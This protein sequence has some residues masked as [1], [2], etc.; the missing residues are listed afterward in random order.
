MKNKMKKIFSISVVAIL[1]AATFMSCKD[2]NRV[3]LVSYNVGVFS[4]WDLSSEA[5]SA[6]LMKELNPDVIVLQELDSCT[7]R[8]GVERFQAKTFAEAMGPEWED[9][10]AAALKTYKKGSYGIVE[11][12]NKEKMK[13]VRTFH[14]M[15]PKGMA[16]EERAVIV[17]EYE[18]MV[19]AG[20][21]LNG[22]ASSL[23]PSV[24]I[25]T[26]TLKALYGNSSKPVFL[27]GDFNARPDNPSIDYLRKHW[28]ILTPEGATGI[29]GKNR[30]LPQEPQT[31]EEV[32]GNCIDYIMVLK[33]KAEVKLL[34]S[35]ICF[36]FSNGSAFESSDHLPIYV[37]VSF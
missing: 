28:T 33:N 36:K 2:S 24:E 8:C 34:D 20:T 7:T 37:D 19:F 31:I 1:L 10:Y 22:H 17:V 4:K 29:G 21:H 12:W 32:K 25:I 30:G 15:L 16:S 13:A 6:A 23:Q 27:G 18:N 26:D 11:V 3:R 5:Y 14:V 35:Q 9:S